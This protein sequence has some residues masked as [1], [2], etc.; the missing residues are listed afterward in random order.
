MSRMSRAGQ[1][2][3]PSRVTGETELSVLLAGMTPEFVDGSFV[4]VSVESWAV[5]S[6][7][8]PLAVVVEDEGLSLVLTQQEADE[9]GLNW[10]FVAAW[11]TLRIRSSLHAVG[12]TAA[13]S[14]ALA[15]AQISCNVIA[16]YHH[17]HLLVPQQSA[18][19]A[20]GILRALAAS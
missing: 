17:D 12:L 18:D 13:V 20:L 6:S 19:E 14:T 5:A 10:D 11:I 9:A 2:R 7:L 1:H 4:F 8:H 16:G 15:G 3:Y